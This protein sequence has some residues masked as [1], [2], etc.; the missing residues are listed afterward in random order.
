MRNS[1]VKITR[2][3]TEAEQ[4]AARKERKDLRE[5]WLAKRAGMGVAEFRA[6]P[7]GDRKALREKIEAEDKAERKSERT[8]IAEKAANEKL[9]RDARKKARATV[10]KDQEQSVGPTRVSVVMGLGKIDS[11]KWN[12]F[13]K[14]GPYWKYLVNF[15][16]RKRYFKRHPHLAEDAVERA[17]LKISRFMASG[18]FVYKEEGKGYFRAFLKTVAVRCAIDILNQ[19]KRSDIVPGER[20]G[21]EPIPAAEAGKLDA[22][23]TRS[24]EECN[25]R[26]NTRMRQT[27]SADQS[28]IWDGLE[29]DAAA[30]VRT[31]DAYDR[32]TLL[33]P[34]EGKTASKP[35]G[36]YLTS[37]NDV[38]VFSDDEAEAGD[39]AGAFLRWREGASESE[40]TA[41][42]R[43]QIHVLYQALGFVLADEKVPQLRRIVLH[44]LYWE[45]LKPGDI[46][47][48]EEFASKDQSTFYKYIKDS[49]D[50]LRKKTLQM[51]RLVM[52]E[53]ESASE[54]QVL[55]FWVELGASPRRWKMA[56]KLRARAETDG[57]KIC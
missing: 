30:D 15:I 47:K 53:G 55:R 38:N 7:R 32:D 54:A 8:R 13:F 14:E 45:H 27:L 35:T 4:Q 26:V 10:Q 39:D 31:L 46:W 56:K 48:R 6:L 2:K 44:L 19:E 18:K 24:L 5:R 40:L 9:R 34:S 36:H 42:Q 16:L 51:W 23:E 25:A 49:K 33:N 17:I 12:L 28:D 43:M 29:S 57:G 52:P 50:V 21:G 1:R 11:R 20:P 22:L 41:L 37:I 3:L